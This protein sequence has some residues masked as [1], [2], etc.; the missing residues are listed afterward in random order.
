MLSKDDDEHAIPVALRGKFST[1]IASFV[2]GDFTTRHEGVVP[3]SVEVAGLIAR[4]VRAYGDVLVP[5]RAETWGG[6]SYRWMNGYWQVIVD[7]STE[8]EPVSDLALHA[9]IGDRPGLP[10]TVYGVWVP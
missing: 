9:R 3:I 8:G 10:I 5:L 1:L 2:T 7:L 6:S 4:N